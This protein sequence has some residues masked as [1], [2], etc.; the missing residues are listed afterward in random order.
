MS[1]TGMHPRV[2]APSR[3]GARE[4]LVLA[5]LLLVGATV[6]IAADRIISGR[7]ES[8]PGSEAAVVL[9]AT[10]WATSGAVLREQV[11]RAMN[12]VLAR[13]TATEWT[14]HGA[15]LRERMNRAMNAVLAREAKAEWATAGAELRERVN[16]A[17]NALRGAEE[18][19]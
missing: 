1:A 17:M 5:A 6:G 10:G 14:T 18:N 3:S 8:N 16:R 7:T 11:N 13:Q 12:A 2:Q 19:T 4:A 15:E 9:P